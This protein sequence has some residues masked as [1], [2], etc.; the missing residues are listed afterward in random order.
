MKNF[1]IQILII[2]L[3]YKIL[4]CQNNTDEK[5]LVNNLFKN[6]DK[7]I[8][9]E[10][11]GYIRIK[12][13]LKQIVSL[14]ERNQLTTTSL[15]LFLNWLDS[16]FAW[17]PLLNNNITFLNVNSNSIWLPDL[18]IINTA[19]TNGFLTF[20]SSNLGHLN[21]SGVISFKIP[22]I[23][24]SVNLKILNKFFEIFLIIGINTKCSMNIYKFPYDRQ[25]CS[26]QLG[27][28]SSSRLTLY[29]DNSYLNQSDV[30]SDFFQNSLWHLLETNISKSE[31][32]EIFF[33]FSLQ[34]KGLYYMIN[35]VFP[36][37]VVNILTLATYFLTFNL[38][39]NISKYQFTKYN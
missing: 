5:I 25:S 11:N 3:L 18:Y 7:T 12:L 6:Y 26:I 23:G 20:S 17:D 13:E 24:K 2:S 38:Q 19:D 14:D 27:S 31:S 10:K 15:V 37:L 34:R 8:L 16:R 1:R 33:N 39:I 9:P 22:L 21:Y 29:I 35:Y 28:W 30:S 4:N 32:N 36:Y